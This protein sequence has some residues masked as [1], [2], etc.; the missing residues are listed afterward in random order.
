MKRS[1]TL[2]FTLVIPILFCASTV[3]SQTTSQS[4]AASQPPPQPVVQSQTQ[5]SVP[6]DCSELPA[7]KQHMAADEK[8]LQDWPE[9]MRYRDANSRLAPPSKDEQR[10]VFLGDSITD[11]WSYPQSGGFFPGKPYVNRG[12]GGQT[13][14]QMLIRYRP[15]VIALQPKVVVILAGTNDIAGNTGPMP[16]SAIEDNFATMVELART[17]KIRVV[18]SSILPVSDYGHSHEGAALVQT[19]RRPPQKILEL[20]E[21]LKKYA[22]ENNCVYLDYFSHVVDEH[23]MLKRELSEDGLHPNAQGYSIMAPLA[24]QAIQAA[25]RKH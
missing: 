19:E 18:L 3:F 23:G 21:W 7:L 10:V 17:H 9:L 24:E 13:T 4:Q 15:D 22:A 1:L 14:P 16:L 11:L 25:L 6:A 2:K 8:R 20:N 12:I 5:S